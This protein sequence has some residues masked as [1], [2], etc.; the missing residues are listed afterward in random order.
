LPV[1][2]ARGRRAR[3]TA[4]EFIIRRAPRGA[5]APPDE[6]R[7]P[8]GGS[9]AGVAEDAVELRG[10]LHVA[11]DIARSHHERWDG[12]G[13]P[14]RLAG[15]CIP[16]AARLVALADVYDALRSR[17]IYKPGLSHHTAVRTVA[18]GSPGHFDP[19]LVAVFVQVAPQ[20][21]RIFRDAGE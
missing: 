1:L 15:E 3:G 17:R 4:R 19:A 12:T 11:T 13:Y 7:P 8:A 10:D 6:P 21:D 2:G 9:L 14:D 16:L 18:D 5:T 20:L